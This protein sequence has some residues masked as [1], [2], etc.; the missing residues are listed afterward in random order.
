MCTHMCPHVGRMSDL[1]GNMS[2][3]LQMYTHSGRGDCTYRYLVVC[4]GVSTP[5]RARSPYPLREGAHLSGAALTRA[6]VRFALVCP[7][8]L[9]Q[10]AKI[11]VD[12]PD[13]Q[14]G[15]IPVL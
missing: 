15:T 13:I 5:S 6:G 7:A 14:A 8:S 10:T 12:K 3:Y 1:W 9:E 2:T 4:P 11:E